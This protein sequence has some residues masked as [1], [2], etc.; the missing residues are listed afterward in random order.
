MNDAQRR[1]ATYG[2]LGPGRPNHRQVAMLRGRWTTGSVR[3][4]LRDEGWGAAQ[5]FPGLV[6]GEGSEVHVDLLESDDLPQN[7]ARLDAFEGQGY[8][9]VVADISTAAGVVRACIYVLSRS[10]KAHTSGT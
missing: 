8:Q 2:T 7:W 10:S 4:Q 6:L 5:G 9:R 3:G 1:L